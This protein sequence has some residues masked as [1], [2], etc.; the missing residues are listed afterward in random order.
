VSIAAYSAL[1]ELVNDE[2]D[3]SAVNGAIAAL[4]D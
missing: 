1:Y 4:E 2:F 3:L